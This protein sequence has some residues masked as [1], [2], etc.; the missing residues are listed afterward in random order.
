MSTS[1]ILNICYL[2]GSLGFIIGLK[3]L[4]KPETAR[5][6]NWVAAVGMGIAIFGTIFLYIDPETGKGITNL[7][8]IFGGMLI[9]TILGTMSAKKVQMTAMPQMVSIFNGMG[10]ICAGLIGI[11]EFRHLIHLNETPV[12]TLMTGHALI[13]LLG[14][15]IGTVSFA[16]SVVAFL[17]LNGNLNDYSFKGQTFFN[18]FFLVAVFG[19]ALFMMNGDVANAHMM[20]YVL[21]AMACVYG[22][23]FVM[24]IGG[25]DMP[26]VIS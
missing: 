4:S 23:S 12:G 2:I 5:K 13:I 14:L 15:I 18:L 21:F 3:M 16:G 9:G 1:A 19:V 7:T 24:P 26:V 10:G 6:G 22:I 20:M 17:K 25:A 8:W 11:I